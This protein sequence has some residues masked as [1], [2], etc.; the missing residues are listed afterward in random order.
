[1]EEGLEM[2]QDLKQ[3]LNGNIAEFLM[4]INNRLTNSKK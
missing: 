4:K 2:I 1:M 3:I